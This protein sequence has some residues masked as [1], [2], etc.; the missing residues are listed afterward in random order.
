VDCQPTA[1]Q[2]GFA[3]YRSLQRIDGQVCIAGVCVG[4]TQ[5]LL[6]DGKLRDP[7]NDHFQV[8]QGEFFF[9]EGALGGGDDE[10]AI[11]FIGIQTQDFLGLLKGGS[12]F[13]LAKEFHCVTRGGLDIAGALGHPVCHRG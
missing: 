12:R 8:L 11:D 7:V 6:R 10:L 1:R 4:E 5:L 2:A 13:T 9:A 3:F